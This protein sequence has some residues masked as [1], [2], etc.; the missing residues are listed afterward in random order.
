MPA[1]TV[2]ETDILADV[3]SSD[4][5]DLTPDVAR[6]VLRWKF[7][8]RAT[9][10]IN[11]LARRNQKGIITATE[12]EELERYMRV[13]SLINLLQAKARLSLSELEG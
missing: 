5:G 10:H 2:T 9:S 11:R 7:S 1:A 4:K 8:R 12:R 13:G 3:L 6:S